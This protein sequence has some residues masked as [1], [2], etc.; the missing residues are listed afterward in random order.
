MSKYKLIE[1]TYATPYDAFRVKELRFENGDYA[2]FFRIAPCL[3]RK[4]V[5]VKCYINGE[6]ESQGDLYGDF[7][8]LTPAEAYRLA[9]EVCIYFK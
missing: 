4:C 2:R 5:R 6:Y 8:N 3:G 9:K 7:D 1:T